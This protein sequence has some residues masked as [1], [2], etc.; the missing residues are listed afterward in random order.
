MERYSG[1]WTESL[2]INMLILL[3]CRF[4]T[5]PIKDFFFL[6]DNSML[7]QVIIWKDKGTRIAKTILRK[8]K[9]EAFTL[10]GFK[11]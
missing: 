10:P 4:K 9:V 7:N 1:S 3:N 8:N 5:T 11:T 2:D 6:L